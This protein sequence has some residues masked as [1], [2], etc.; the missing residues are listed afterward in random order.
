MGEHEFSFQTYAYSRT[1]YAESTIANLVDAGRTWLLEHPPLPAQVELYDKEGNATGEIVSPDPLNLS[2]SKMIFTKAALKDGRLAGNLVA[3]GQ[4]F[5]QD[6]DATTV[7]RT[8]SGRVAGGGGAKNSSNRLT[9]ILEGPLL[10]AQWGK[11][12][13]ELV[14]ELS[15]SVSPL[16]VKAITYLKTLLEVNST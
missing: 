7:S 13:P 4:L 1:R 5:N 16:V 9:F 15:L 3:M 11:G 2:V 8:L 12:E 10:L 14:A 6:V